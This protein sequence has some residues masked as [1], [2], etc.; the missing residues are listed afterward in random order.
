MRLKWFRP[1]LYSLPYY[2]YLKNLWEIPSFAPYPG[3]GC[4]EFYFPKKKT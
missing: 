3:R 4:C 1:S 2:T